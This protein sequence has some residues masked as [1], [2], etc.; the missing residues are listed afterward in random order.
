MKTVL[1]YIA[2]AV[3]ALVVVTLLAVP[4][5]HVVRAAVANVSHVIEEK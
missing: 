4:L 2:L 5:V 1:T 3:F